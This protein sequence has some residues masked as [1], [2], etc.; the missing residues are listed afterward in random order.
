M[1]KLMFKLVFLVFFSVPSWAFADSANDEEFCA[2]L[3]DA[4]TEMEDTLL[5]IKQRKQNDS[6]F[7]KALNNSQKQ[8]MQYVDA[9]L[10]MQFPSQQFIDYGSVLPMCQCVA[11]LGLVQERIVTL[12]QWLEPVMEG[13]VCTGSKR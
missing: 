9:E 1:N 10:L 11:R 6:A 3:N 2:Q 13:D 8:W 7:L 12:K 4:K 5:R